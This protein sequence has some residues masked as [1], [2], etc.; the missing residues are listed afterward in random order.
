MSSIKNK[1]TP[2]I[3]LVV[4]DNRTTVMMLEEILVN[5][6]YKVLTAIDG[7]S[8]RK[9][10]LKYHRQLS[11]ILLD[12]MM[13]DIDGLELARWV[14]RSND[15]TRIPIII[16][17]S[18]QQPE[19]IREG[20]EAGVF[21]YLTKPIQEEVLNSVVKSAVKELRQQKILES[22]LIKHKASFKLLERAL[23]NLSTLE[24]AESVS[25]F[26]ANCFP[27]PAFVLPAIAELIVN[28]IEHGNC[29]FSYE[30]KSKLIADGTWKEEVR[31]R[32]KSPEYKKKS[33][34]I[35]FI[36]EDTKYSVKITDQGSGFDWQKYL[37]IDPARALDNHGRGIAR[38]NM[39][40]DTLTYNKLGNQVIGMIDNLEE[41]NFEW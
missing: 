40:F 9:M 32:V 12:R 39:I 19:Q 14:N 6:G 18:S 25:C 22:E 10:I 34:E 23:F 38:A 20:I 11:A 33:V 7:A 31:N 36:K 4:D 17:T 15:I 37:S 16:Q 24:E 1:E 41:D 21:Y 13:P 5:Q 30:D 35:V 27:K 28:A 3:I 8:A 29:Q 2:A 26:I